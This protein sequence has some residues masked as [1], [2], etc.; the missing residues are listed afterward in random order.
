MVVIIGEMQWFCT[1]IYTKT[2][3]MTSYN[4]NVSVVAMTLISIVS[5]DQTYHN[6]LCMQRI[7]PQNILFRCETKA[8]KLSSL[9][10]RL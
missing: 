9:V 3:V 2:Y 4:E 6:L 8:A 5:G 10:S 1:R 7:T